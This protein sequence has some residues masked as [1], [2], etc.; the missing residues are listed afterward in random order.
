MLKKHK[1]SLF[2]DSIFSMISLVIG[3][4]SASRFLLSSIYEYSCLLPLFFCL[5][6]FLFPI[7]RNRFITLALVSRVDTSEIAYNETPGVIRYLIYL[8]FL[9]SLFLSIADESIKG[10]TYATHASRKYSYIMA[11]CL[12]IFYIIIETFINLENID[13]YTAFRDLLTLGLGMTWLLLKLKRIAIKII[14]LKDLLY[15]S[16]GLLAS[17]IINVSFYFDVANYHYLSYDSLKSISTLPAL[18]YLSFNMY[19]FFIFSLAFL[20]PIIIAYSSKYLAVTFIFTLI[21]MQLKK[22][23]SHYMSFLFCLLFSIMIYQ[24][25]YL[26]PENYI[27]KSRI[28]NG[29]LTDKTYSD[30]FDYLN[31]LDPI[32]YGE[33]FLFFSQP[34]YKILFG[35]GIGAGLSDLN[36]YFYFVNPEMN[37][38]SVDELHKQIYYRLHDPFLY[39]GLRFGIFPVTF[40]VYYLV[41]GTLRSLA[42]KKSIFA[43]A[44]VVFLNASF[45]IAGL[46]MTAAL[47]IQCLSISGKYDQDCRLKKSDI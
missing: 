44:F 2:S 33:Y 29:F 26:L 4:L 18:Y 32:R 9:I 28:L 14:Y 27:L 31:I 45:S 30:F 24:L 41:K 36:N 10:K 40:I 13:I 47:I 39:I 6:F 1:L 19:L 46:L 22:I 35:S 8:I 16:I 12:Y 25:Y 23:Q 34:V 15:F 21:I 43:L 37:A 17:E 3:F 5:I 20:A 7:L 11:S 42:E 38:F